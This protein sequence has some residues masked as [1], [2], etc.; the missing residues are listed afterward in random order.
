MI[1]KNGLTAAKQSVPV[2]PQA[3]YFREAGSGTPV[4]CIH[5]SASSS[6]QWRALTERLANRFRVIAVDLYGSG[7]T[8]AWPQDQPMHLDDEVALLRSVF[9]AAPQCRNCLDLPGV[10]CRREPPL[11]R[12][13][14]RS[15]AHPPSE[16]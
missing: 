13:L 14:Q 8:A 7:K 12:A 6:A 5:S 4:V 16:R 15:W 11:S 2:P 1:T 10:W 3:P 9:R